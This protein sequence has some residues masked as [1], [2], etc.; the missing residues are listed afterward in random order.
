MKILISHRISSSPYLCH[1]WIRINL[2]MYSGHLVS[3]CEK[4]RRS[5]KSQRKCK[6]DI[7]HW[8]SNSTW[9]ILLW[10]S[11]WGNSHAAQVQYLIYVNTDGYNDRHTLCFGIPV[12]LVF[13][14]VPMK[15]NLSEIVFMKEKLVGFWLKVLG[16][17]L[18]K[19]A[20]KPWKDEFVPMK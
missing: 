13:I 16:G 17:T 18:S 6:L 1:S 4:S 7:S 9:T 10:D 8:F 19:N 15:G 14:H 20:G 3:N 5:Q 12:Y 11:Y 2:E